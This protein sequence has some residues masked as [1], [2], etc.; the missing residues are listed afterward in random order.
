MEWECGRVVEECRTGCPLTEEGRGYDHRGQTYRDGGGFGG[1]SSGFLVVSGKGDRLPELSVKEGG[2]RAARVSLIFSSFFPF[3]NLSFTLASGGLASCVLGR[4]DGVRCPEV[5]PGNQRS[6]KRKRGRGRC[7][8]RST[9]KKRRI[10]GRVGK[11]I[12][13]RGSGG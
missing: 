11:G 3:T 13:R 5:H 1:T 8:T 12:T 2:V 6:R 4:N 10:R 7:A 9:M